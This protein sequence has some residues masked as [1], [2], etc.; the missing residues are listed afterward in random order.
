MFTIL[1]LGISCHFFNSKALSSLNV[2]SFP[3]LLR[4]SLPSQ[5][6]VCSPDQSASLHAHGTKSP[7]V[8]PQGTQFDSLRNMSTNSLKC[9][10][11]RGG[12]Q[13]LSCWM[14]TEIGD[15]LLMNRMKETCV[16]SETGPWKALQLLPWSLSLITH[17]GRFHSAVSSPTER[18]TW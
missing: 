6:H 1:E 3:K 4:S 15:L 16:A 2:A 5:T 13:F 17:S 14:R 12:V 10:P 18:S 8:S 7:W 11:L 9:F